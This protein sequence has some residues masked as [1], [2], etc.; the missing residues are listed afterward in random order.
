MSDPNSLSARG[1]RAMHRVHARISTMARPATGF[2]SMPEPRTIGL[3]ARG[4]QLVA[5]NFLFA[6]HLVTAPDMS[7]WDIDVPDEVFGQDLHGFAW[8]DDL[9]AVGDMRAR[10]KAQRWVWGWIEA[11]GR[12]R[13]SDGSRRG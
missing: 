9:A 11:H 6:G 7:I 12:G 4:K 13:G 8:L 5:G 1:T 2:T 10:D 3:F